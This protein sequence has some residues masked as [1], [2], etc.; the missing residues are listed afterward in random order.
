M[1]NFLKESNTWAL[2]IV[3]VAFTFVP[4]TIFGKL[5][6]LPYV[7][8][9]AN[10]VLT[11]VL[12]FIVVLLLSIIINALYLHF[13]RRICIKGKNYNIQIE[14]GDL[15]KM[16]ACKK[17]ISFDECF[18]TVVG[19]ETPEI[20]SSSICGQY[21]I[22]NPIQDMKSLIDKANLKPAKSKSKYQNQNRYDSGKLVPNGDYLLM[23]FAKL[24][25]T[26][27]GRFFSRDEFLECLSLLW[28]EIDKYYA[29]KDVCIP[30]L[31]SGITRMDGESSGILTQQ[32]LLDIIIY[33]YK[34]SS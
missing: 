26:G 2:S 27:S 3:T 14:Y 25:E 10:I 23:A 11:R 22:N 17:V 7:S 21:L 12:A 1:L 13:R 9:E 15:L 24:D 34:L 5:K 31:G 30:I 32:E 8:D 4:E 6:L 28:K 16:R 33:S 18:T 29:Q 20:K 19:E